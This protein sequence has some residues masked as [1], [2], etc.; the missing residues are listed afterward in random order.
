M[1]LLTTLLSLVLATAVVAQ[2]YDENDPEMNA[3]LDAFFELTPCG[4][5]VSGLCPEA[6][7]MLRGGGDRLAGYLIHQLELP[8]PTTGSINH[9]TYL[10]LL[11]HTESATA[12]THLTSLVNS[13]ADAL[14]A[15]STQDS[16]PLIFAVEALGKTRDLRALPLVLAL[17]DRFNNAELRIR[18]VNAADRIQAKHGPQ[19]EITARL[20]ALQAEMSPAG[21]TAMASGGSSDARLA[22]RV[23]AILATPGQT[24]P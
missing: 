9:D 18:A 4:P 7:D 12:Y 11:G 14:A 19:A 13:R 24:Q 15:D 21:A 22:R 2:P 17:I 3:L 6:L 8:E 16:M 23:D 10:Q 1:R 20:S 5:R